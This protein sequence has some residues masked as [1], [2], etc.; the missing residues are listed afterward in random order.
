M[1]FSQEILIDL[2]REEVMKKMQDTSGYKYW[3]RGFISY[4]NLS[5]LQG[6]KD[7]RSRIKYKKGKKEIEMIETIIKNSY[8]KKFYSS[9]EARD[10]F[11][12]HENHF[13]KVSIDM[14]RWISDIEIRFSG[15]IKI[16][17]LIR[18]GGFKSSSLHLSRIL[19][20]T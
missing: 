15:I 12:K 7:A 16:K 3:Q 4:Q 2:P 6:K 9:Y 20:I 13:E 19:K 18:P 1:K 14:T 5:G 8:P 11:S 17:S 10:S